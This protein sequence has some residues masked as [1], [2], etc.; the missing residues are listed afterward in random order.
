VLNCFVIKSR[1]NGRRNRKNKLF[2]RRR[3]FIVRKNRG[4]SIR[5]T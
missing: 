2:I 4:K 5:I 3:Q 1:L